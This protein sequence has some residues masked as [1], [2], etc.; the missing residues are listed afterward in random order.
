MFIALEMMPTQLFG[1]AKTPTPLATFWLDYA[2]M[3]NRISHRL[4][5]T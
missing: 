4:S 1:G 2:P 5:S 3:A